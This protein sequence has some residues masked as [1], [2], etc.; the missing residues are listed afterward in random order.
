MFVSLRALWPGDLRTISSPKRFNHGGPPQ[1][2]NEEPLRSGI[3]RPKVGFL[4]SYPDGGQLGALMQF[5][6]ENG[7]FGPPE[8][9]VAGVEVD[10]LRAPLGTLFRKADRA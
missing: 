4:F 3:S 5:A 1:S 10:N 8:A 7:T 2:L 9:A 6:V